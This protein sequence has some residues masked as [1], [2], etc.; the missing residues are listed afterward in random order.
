MIQKQVFSL[1][2]LLAAYFALFP[3]SAQALNRFSTQQLLSDADTVIEGEVIGVTETPQST[4]ANILVRGTFKGSLKPGEII[5]VK[6]E[7]GKVFI[8]PDEPSFSRLEHHVLFLI[9]ISSSPAQFRCV[10]QADGQ[11]R[12]SNDE[13]VYPYHDNPAH[14]VKRSEYLKELKP[15]K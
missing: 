8:N 12:V 15:A 4:M 5:S 13:N 3:Q 1:T 7:R 2:F 11:K 9:K 6:S 14:S 10:N